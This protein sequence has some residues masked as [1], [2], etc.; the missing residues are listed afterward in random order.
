MLIKLKGHLSCDEIDFL[1]SSKLVFASITRVTRH[2]HVLRVVHH[3]I[4]DR[5]VAPL[6]DTYTVVPR[7]TARFDQK[8]ASLYSVCARSFVECVES[9]KNQAV[10]GKSHI[11]QQIS[12]RWRER[13]ECA[14]MS[15]VHVEA[16]H[17][18]DRS[19]RGSRMTCNVYVARVS[20]AGSATYR[21]CIKSHDGRHR[22]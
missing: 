11:H 19:P 5:P 22:N 14:C 16:F 15:T 12:I 10:P 21:P 13:F 18:L 6:G 8:T 2:S 9:S 4:K 1:F 3:L 7:S 17:P 20:W